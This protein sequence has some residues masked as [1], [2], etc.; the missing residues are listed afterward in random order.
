MMAKFK[1]QECGAIEEVRCKP[2]KCKSC[3]AV[4]DKI[5]KEEAGGEKT[6]K[7]K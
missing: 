4:K 2:A 7:K 3:G 1:C 6:V 5:I